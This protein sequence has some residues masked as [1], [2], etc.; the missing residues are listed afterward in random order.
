[1]ITVGSYDYYQRIGRARYEKSMDIGEQRIVDR[2]PLFR[3]VECQH[4][5][6]VAHFKVEQVG[7]KFGHG[8]VSG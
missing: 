6:A 4:G 8:S 1:M 7:Q 2:I 3:S 5:D